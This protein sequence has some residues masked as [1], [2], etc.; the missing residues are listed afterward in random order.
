MLR[1]WPQFL[2]PFISPKEE[3]EESPDRQKGDPL[4]VN[5]DG[6]RGTL[7]DD[8]RLLVSSPAIDAGDVNKLPAILTTD[9]NFVRP[10]TPGTRH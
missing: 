2:E 7:N 4:F 5:P 1:K 3:N 9:F 8:V 10:Q 6:I